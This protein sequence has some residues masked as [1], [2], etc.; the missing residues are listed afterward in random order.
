VTFDGSVFCIESNHSLSEIMGDSED[1]IH[2][3]KENRLKQIATEVGNEYIGGE[4]FEK[5]ETES[6]LHGFW[7][8]NGISREHFDQLDH[9]I[10][11]ELAEGHGRHSAQMLHWDNRKML[12]DINQSDVGFCKQRFGGNPNYSIILNNGY[13]CRPLEDMSCTAAFSYD[14]MVHFNSEVVPSYLY[15]RYRV[16]KPGGQALLHRSNYTGNPGG[17]FRTIPGWRNY[18]SQSLFIHYSRMAGFEVADSIVFA[19]AI[20]D[21]DCLTLIKKPAVE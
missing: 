18:M 16:L 6:W 7:D 20:P 14:S 17:D 15:D 3:S 8:P 12:V 4:Y 11:L 13:D 10:I 9:S 21:N 5:G 2:Q 1:A 19:W